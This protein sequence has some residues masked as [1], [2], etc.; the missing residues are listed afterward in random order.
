MKYPQLVPERVCKTDITVYR[1][2]G[3]NRDGSPKHTVIFEGKC[4]Y[5]EKTKTKLTADKQLITLSGEALF[6][7]DIAP[8][9]DTITGEVSFL[10]GI[11]RKIHAS[12]K[13]KNPDGT[14][15]YTRLELI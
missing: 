3:I 5:S 15:N 1:T 11:T 9:T 14:V 13:A 10:S 4:F 2:D 6:N 12:E 7:G 8:D